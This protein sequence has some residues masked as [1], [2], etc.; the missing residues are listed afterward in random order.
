MLQQIALIR[1][2][3][4]VPQQGI[5]EG[6]SATAT[7]IDHTLGATIGTGTNTTLHHLETPIWTHI[8]KIIEIGTD[9][10]SQ[11]L[12]HRTTDIGASVGMTH[13]EGTPDHTADPH[14]AAYLNTDTLTHTAI[15]VTHH[16]GDPPLT[17][18]SPEITANPDPTKLTK[19]LTKHQAV[20]PTTP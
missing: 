18:A 16:T 2:R 19:I 17:E 20:H 13:E 3:H 5:E 7:G 9:T 6:S 14:I 15:D 4:Q 8:T 1:Y 12:T 10:A 11:D